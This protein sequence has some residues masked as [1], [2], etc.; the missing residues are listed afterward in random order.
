MEPCPPTPMSLS[1]CDSLCLL[2]WSSTLFL[3]L[4]HSLFLGPALSPQAPFQVPVYKPPPLCPGLGCETCL[5]KPFGVRWVA[6]LTVEGT[7]G[8]E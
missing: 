4:F 1:L 5:N 2:S 7:W 8:A 6:V 3:Y